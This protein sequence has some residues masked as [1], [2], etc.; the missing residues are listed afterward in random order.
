MAN[1]KNKSRNKEI[2]KS[3]EVSS[4]HDVKDENGNGIF[5][6]TTKYK[7]VGGL[8]VFLFFFTSFLVYGTVE[9]WF[10]AEMWQ[11]TIWSL[12]GILSLY[13]IF[14]KSIAAL[15]LNLVLFLAVSLLPVWQSFYESVVK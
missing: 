4:L 1:K 8:S 14:K 2:D 11:V 3:F 9:K 13:S 7:W 15:I 6:I 5:H 12:C 10:E